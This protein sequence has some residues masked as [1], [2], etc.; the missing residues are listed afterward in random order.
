MTEEAW[1]GRLE[2]R[3]PDGGRIEVTDKTIVAMGDVKAYR[4][5][6][7]THNGGKGRPACKIVFEIR[8]GAPACASFE[9]LATNRMPVRAKDL[10]AFKLDELRETVYATAGVFVPQSDGTWFLTVGF[11]REDRNH[12]EQASRRRKMTPELLSRIAE[13]HTNAPDDGHLDAVASAF[14][15][16]QRQAWRY[17]AQ[18]REKGLIK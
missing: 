17:I 1:A 9:L 8:N 7:Y 4:Q 6:T 2:C 14:G 11:S 12:V 3:L 18:A 5:L 16:S 10:R 15:V 13:V